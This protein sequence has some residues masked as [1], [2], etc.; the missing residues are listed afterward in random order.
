MKYVGPLVVYKIKDPINCLMTT[1]DDKI[2][3]G[4]FKHDRLK[5]AVIGTS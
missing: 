4:L 1:L 5:P 3:R 2:L